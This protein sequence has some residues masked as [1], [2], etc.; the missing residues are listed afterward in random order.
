MPSEEEDNPIQELLPGEPAAGATS[1]VSNISHMQ[2]RLLS[3]PN[4][5]GLI[6]SSQRLLR[7]LSEL[8]SVLLIPP[9]AA[10]LRARN[11]H[12]CTHIC[13]FKM[14]ISASQINQAFGNCCLPTSDPLTPGPTTS[15]PGEAAVTVVCHNSPEVRGHCNICSWSP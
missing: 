13:E 1:N 11:K 15:P 8:T 6:I 4:F 5:R 10:P 12:A 7:W 14:H 2:I 9:L 3:V